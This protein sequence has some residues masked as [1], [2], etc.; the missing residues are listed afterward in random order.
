MAE[1]FAAPA[2]AVPVS[3]SISDSLLLQRRRALS[4]PLRCP[5]TYESQ[6]QSGQY[7][8]TAAVVCMLVT[9]CLVILR[10][11]QPG[12]NANASKDAAPCAY[13]Q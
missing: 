3:V 4:A 12:A 10:G 11:G 9:L 8:T 13:S 5:P 7:L 1:L 2:S 6:R